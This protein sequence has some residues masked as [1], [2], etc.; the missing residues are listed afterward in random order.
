MA[1][2]LMLLVG[3][4]PLCWLVAPSGAT[5]V[6]L[7][8][9]TQCILHSLGCGPSGTPGGLIRSLHSHISGRHAVRR[10]RPQCGGCSYRA[11]HG[12]CCLSQRRAEDKRGAPQKR[13]ESAMV[14]N[15]NGTAT[16]MW[17]SDLHTDRS[18]HVN[19]AAQETNRITHHFRAAIA[20]SWLSGLPQLPQPRDPGRA[21][22]RSVRAPG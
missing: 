21:T 12:F 9:C 11:G 15:R 19:K 7:H 16:E 2:T 13:M 5:P 14:R 1:A 6:P 20:Q 3:A 22:R 8:T 10:P 18:S 17:Q 4:T